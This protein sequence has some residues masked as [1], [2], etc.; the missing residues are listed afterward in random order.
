M[1]SAQQVVRVHRAG[2]ALEGAA[3]PRTVGLAL[4]I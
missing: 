3:D 4:G 2:R 1:T